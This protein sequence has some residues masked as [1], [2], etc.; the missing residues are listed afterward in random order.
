MR[1]GCGGGGG[2]AAANLGSNGVIGGNAEVFDGDVEG[3]EVGEEGV[4]EG[5]AERVGAGDDFEGR[6]RH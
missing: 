3:A 1:I 2:D 5:A 4:F 6:N